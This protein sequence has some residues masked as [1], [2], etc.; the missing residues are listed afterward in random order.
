MKQGAPSTKART[1]LRSLGAA[2]LFLTIG[3]FVAWLCLPKP[4]LME[5][6]SFSRRV[7]DRNEHQLWMTLS[8]DEKYRV[9]TP[10]DR[11]S[12]QL[13]RA[14]L[15]HEDR[16]F[17][18]HP[19]VN[20]IAAIR[21]FWHFARGEKRGGASTITMQLA[22]L[23]SHGET[24]TV[25]GKLSQMLHALELERHYSKSELLE[26]YLNLAPYGRNIEGVGAA[27][28]IYFGKEAAQLS[29]HEAIALSL[30]PQSPSRRALREMGSSVHNGARNRLYV[31]L[32]KSSRPVD[33]SF[34][35]RAE[36]KRAMLAPHFAT[37]VL[38]KNDAR[39]IR[40]TL[41]LYLQRLV[42]RRIA[43]YVEANRVRGIRNA[44][45][46]LVDF[47]TMEVLA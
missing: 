2:F 33:Q 9:F 16:F 45:V 21:A 43:D 44:A 36:V 39:E 29:V 40:T 37:Q 7:F 46:L 6:I 38:A 11:I 32:T 25:R 24:R 19:G 3:L 30:I 5:K 20:P 23:S 28:E 1:I 22:R 31:A 10:L 42:E 27:S 34:I 47:S 8:R 35:A 26:A 13:I 17:W 41:D 12:P 18:E 4:A 15:E 14:T